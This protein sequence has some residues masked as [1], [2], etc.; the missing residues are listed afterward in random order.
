MAP[1]LKPSAQSHIPPATYRRA[2]PDPARPPSGH[3]YAIIC[4]VNA[5]KKAQRAL[6]A[7]FMTYLPVAVHK[8]KVGGRRSLEA[9]VERALFPRYLFV[10][11]REM[12]F[13][14]YDLKGVNGVES[15]VRVDGLPM[16]IPH[17]VIGA[18]MARE[19]VGEFVEPGIETKFDKDEIQHTSAYLTLEDVGLSTGSRAIVKRGL[20]EGFE[21]II[22]ALMPKNHAQVL[23]RMFGRDVPVNVP[24]ADLEAV[25]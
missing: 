16:P 20:Q 12:A 14:F 4:N 2:R 13:R 11:S 18:I 10:A 19:V 15:I 1:R 21:C 24:L 25:A 6:G 17:A 22:N 8:R 9:I 23:I 7:G 5:E 3:W